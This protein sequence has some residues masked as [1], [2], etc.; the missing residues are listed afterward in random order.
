MFKDQPLSELLCSLLA[1]RRRRSL[2]TQASSSHGPHGS[3]RLP[4]SGPASTLPLPSCWPPLGSTATA[5]PGR[6][7]PSWPSYFSSTSSTWGFHA[8]LHGMHD[9]GSNKWFG[10]CANSWFSSVCAG[11]LVPHCPAWRRV[12][13]H[14]HDQG[15]YVHARAHAWPRVAVPRIFSRR[16]CQP[17]NHHGAIWTRSGQ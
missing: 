4:K 17:T 5:D 7:R 1:A 15:S 8:T 14:H 3:L 9:S 13:G 6:K 16:R 12:D 11:S 10:E 2:N